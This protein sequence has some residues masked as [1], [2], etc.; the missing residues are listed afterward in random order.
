M[1][2]QRPLYPPSILNT[3]QQWRFDW[4]AVSYRPDPI[5]SDPREIVIG[6]G[7]S[8]KKDT[9]NI[10]FD[11]I[12]IA[13]SDN[14]CRISIK[15]ADFSPIDPSFVEK[16]TVLTYKTDRNNVT[17]KMIIGSAWMEEDE[18]LVYLDAMPIPNHNVECWITLK[19]KIERYNGPAN[20]ID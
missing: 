10:Q 8:T 4:I 13:D 20:E 14:F 16:W 7:F 3:D 17:K 18:I 5:T 11:A 1:K 6:R 19:P 9:I 15:P 12:P 2:I